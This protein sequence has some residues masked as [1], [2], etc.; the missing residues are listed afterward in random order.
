MAG[1]LYSGAS[2]GSF[3]CLGFIVTGGN[4]HKIKIIRPDY[5]GTPSIIS[6]FTSRAEED[7]DVSLGT[8]IKITAMQGKGFFIVGTSLGNIIIFSYTD[9]TLT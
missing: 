3:I 6:G 7:L 1:D 5:T 2:N 4:D 8:P 9:P